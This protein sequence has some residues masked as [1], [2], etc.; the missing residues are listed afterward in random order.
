[1]KTISFVADWPSANGNWRSE[2]SG[3]PSNRNNR[4][5]A[6][7]VVAPAAELDHDVEAAVVRWAR[8][9]T[10]PARPAPE[11]RAEA[12][13]GQAGYPGHGRPLVPAER[14]NTV[15]DLWPT[16]CGRCERR[17]HPLDERGEP[18]RH[19]VTEL[20]H[21]EAHITEYRC[22]GAGCHDRGATTH[23]ALPDEIVGQFGPQ[24]TAMIAY[25]T[26]VCPLPRLVVHRLL[27]GAL[28]ISI[29]PG[30]TQAA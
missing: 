16:A 26:V 4:G 8:R 11:E 27:E 21:I 6:T 10:T 9:H 24:L 7:A 13:R 19:Q 15:I 3:W 30:R 2:R 28:Q 14:V 23:A 29:S 12:R 1:M 25:L 20:P 5:V 22:H 18:R 17:R